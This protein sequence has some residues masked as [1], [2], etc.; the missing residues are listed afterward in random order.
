MSDQTKKKIVVVGATG[1]IGSAIATHLSELGHE[2]ICV[3]INEEKVKALQEGHIPIFE[4]GLEE[5]VKRNVEQG[6]LSFTTDV[7]QAILD[8][9]IIFVAVG[10]AVTTLLLLLL[11]SA[12]PAA[13]SFALLLSTAYFFLVN[14]WFLTMLRRGSDQVRQRLL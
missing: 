14:F 3:D 12:K 2:V 1:T 10:C 8:S 4:P 9:L 11:A 7:K 5:L 6:R 13:A